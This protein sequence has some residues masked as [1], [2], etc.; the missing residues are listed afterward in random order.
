MPSGWD[1]KVLLPF[2]LG[3]ALVR[4]S[5]YSLGSLPF[6]SFDDHSLIDQLHLYHTNSSIYPPG[7]ISKRKFYSLK[8]VASK[9]VYYISAIEPGPVFKIYLQS[10]PS[11]SWQSS[12]STQQAY[13]SL[14]TSFDGTPALD[15]PD[16]P[17]FT[18]GDD[19][20]GLEHPIV[21]KQIEEMPGACFC[22]SYYKYAGDPL[23][24]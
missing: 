17:V 9:R 5:I 18:S 13:E 24:V 23:E 7:F 12:S 2:V 19:F 4:V 21:R 14:L 8:E 16:W 20:F 3:R 10:D 15:D 6:T 11:L 1:S 22:T